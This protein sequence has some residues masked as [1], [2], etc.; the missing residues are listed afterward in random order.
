VGEIARRY[1]AFVDSFD[2]AR[3]WRVHTA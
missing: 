3:H 1:R 2:K